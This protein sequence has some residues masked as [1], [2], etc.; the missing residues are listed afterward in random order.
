MKNKA[1]NLIRPRHLQKT[2]VNLMP[3]ID[4]LLI[5]QAVCAVLFFVFIF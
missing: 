2:R 3:E 5:V 1:N 4:L